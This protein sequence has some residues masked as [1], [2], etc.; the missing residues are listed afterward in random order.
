MNDPQADEYYREQQ[1]KARRGQLLLAY[2]QKLG[3]SE[4]RLSNN[5]LLFVPLFAS[6]ISITIYRYNNVRSYIIIL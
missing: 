2:A 6:L 5:Y 4:N 1:E 3:S